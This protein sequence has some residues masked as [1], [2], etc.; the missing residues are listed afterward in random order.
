MKLLILTNILTPYRVHFFD[1]LRECLLVR[2]GSLHVLVM[3]ESEP[4][5]SWSYTEYQ[6]CYTTLLR[7][8]TVSLAGAYVHLVRDLKEKIESFSPDCIVCA[9]SYLDPPVWSTILIARRLNVPVYFW[10][11]SHLG[12]NKQRSSLIS[13][14]RESIRRIVYPRFDGFWIAGSL[15]ERFVDKYANNNCPK[16]FVPNI[17]ER[18]IFG[19][20]SCSDQDKIDL[21]SKYGIPL[22]KRI[23][24][25]PARL[26][27]VKGLCEFIKLLGSCKR[28]TECAFVV[29]GDG[30]LQDDILQTAKEEG[31]EVL[32]LGY[33]EQIEIVELYACADFFVMPSLS[34]PNPLTCIEACWSG[35]PLIVSEHVGNH[36]EIVRN[37]VNGYVF[38]YSDPV[39][40]SQMLDKAISSDES[41]I[42]N[43]SRYSRYVAEE[44]Y[45]PT[46][47][48][49]RIVSTMC[50]LCVCE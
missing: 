3:G 35:L 33:R 2:D 20:V 23:L 19:A 16:V 43:A 13:L 22:S 39:N 31:V 45:D 7:G 14:V 38:S 44:K 36:P 42:K 11:E 8:H 9:G 1:C 48:S 46:S 27:K 49:S 50:R 24:F 30:P 37:E 5:R 29:A 28:K 15:S 41:W 34:D 17:V 6:R 32:L 12:E 40:A 4:N 10:S 18:S 25:S 47:N 26:E 21:R